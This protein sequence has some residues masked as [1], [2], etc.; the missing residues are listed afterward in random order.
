VTKETKTK[1][2]KKGL[3]DFLNTNSKKFIIVAVILAGLALAGLA[4]LWW[5]N[6]DVIARVGDTKITQADFDR[7][8]EIGKNQANSTKNKKYSDNEYIKKELIERKLVDKI[9]L[10]NNINVSDKEIQEVLQDLKEYALTYG[11]ND[12]ELNSYA[13]YI[14]L[15][16][17]I[18]QVLTDNRTGR[19]IDVYYR[20][21]NGI[22]KVAGVTTEN[23]KSWANAKAESIRQNI[24][25]NTAKYTEVFNAVKENKPPYDPKVYY[26]GQFGNITREDQIFSRGIRDTIFS[27]NGGEISKVLDNDNEKTFTIIYLVAKNQGR[28]SSYQDILD[29]YQKY[30]SF[31]FNNSPKINISSVFEDLFIRKAYA[32]CKY[33]GPCNGQGACCYMIC[34]PQTQNKCS[35]QI[36]SVASGWG[37]HGDNCSTIGAKCGGGGPGPIIIPPPPPP[38]PVNGKCGSADGNAYKITDPPSGNRCSVGSVSNWRKA[39][40]DESWKWNCNGKNGGTNASCEAWIKYPVTAH[41]LGCA[42]GRVIDPPNNNNGANDHDIYCQQGDPVNSA[43]CTGWY[44]LNHQLTMWLYR[45]IDPD[46]SVFIGWYKRNNQGNLVGYNSNVTAAC[47][48]GV[49]CE[50]EREKT[51]EGENVWAKIGF[52]EKVELSGSGTGTVTGKNAWGVANINCSNVPGSSATTCSDVLADNGD[53]NTGKITLTATENTTDGSTFIGWKNCPKAN[54]KTC[55]YPKGDDYCKNR[56][57]TAVFNNGVNSPPIITLLQPPDR[58]E[59]TTSPQTVHLTAKITDPDNDTVK[60]RLIYQKAPPAGSPPNPNWT[61]ATACTPSI[62]DDEGY[63]AL[64]LQPVTM[65]CSTNIALGEGV[66]YWNAQGEDKDGLPASAPLSWWFKIYNS[67]TPRC[68]VT[69]SEGTVPLAVNV[70][71]FNVPPNLTINMGDGSSPFTPASNPFWYTYTKPSP[72]GDYWHIKASSFDCTVKVKKPSSSSGTEIAP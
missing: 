32:A 30:V 11:M 25:G 6:R 19:F 31:N 36:A 61:V 52:K 2:S 15:R 55:T 50:I 34:G 70:K 68:L 45:K 71:L 66:Y 27:L 17:K 59:Y 13:R 12:K 26:A 54:G 8:K 18:I 28:Y 60:I 24:G 56:T 53:S 43:R 16:Y 47:N 48:D 62:S 38:K 1:N 41:T 58:T 63:T 51:K 33:P 37:Y 57:I 10:D 23:L 46:K 72:P 35:L 14:A 4:G 9:A 67:T 49:G 42:S 22:E 5:I 69:P 44:K 29:E 20:Q 21:G 7:A 39:A 65:T 64:K 40:D 3:V